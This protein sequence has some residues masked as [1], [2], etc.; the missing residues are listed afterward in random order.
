MIALIDYGSGNIKSV[1]KAL[2]KIGA[3]VTLTSDVNTIKGSDAIILPGVSSFY[4]AK[5]NMEEL[6]LFSVIR[7]ELKTNK[8]YLGI[9]LG[10]QLLLTDSEEGKKTAGFDIIKGTVKRFKSG[11]KVPHMGWDKVKQS[12][13]DRLQITGLFKDIPDESYFYFAHSYYVNPDDKSTTI[14]TTEYGLKFS[15]VIN[16]GNTF[17]I[18]FHPEKS[19]DLGL[20]VMENFCKIA[21]EIRK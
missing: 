3:K 4:H 10:M 16:K 21:G 5:E 15:S 19:G 20:R 9:C 11:V 18:Q 14:G 13:E 17:G 1:S 7:S 8:C 2:E 6:N 12:I